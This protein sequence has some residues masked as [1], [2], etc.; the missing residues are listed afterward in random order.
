MAG[1]N[2]DA[3][4]ATLTP[5][6]SGRTTEPSTAPSRAT[7]ASASAGWSMMIC[8]V[9]ETLTSPPAVVPETLTFDAHWANPRAS[10]GA[11]RNP[12]VRRADQF[13]ESRPVS[14]WIWLRSSRPPTSI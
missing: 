5:R 14:I 2:G 12:V 9:T 13:P 6:I 11:P 8:R 4:D 1:P 7:S 10:S 3:A